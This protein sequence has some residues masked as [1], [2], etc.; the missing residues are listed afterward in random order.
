MDAYTNWALKNDPKGE[1]IQNIGLFNAA[2]GMKWQDM[3]DSTVVYRAGTPENRGNAATWGRFSPG[4]VGGDITV[5]GIKAYYASFDART[6]REMERVGSKEP[7]ATRV[8]QYRETK[9]PQGYRFADNMPA[10]MRGYVKD[11]V[12]ELPVKPST[13]RAFDQRA[14]ALDDALKASLSPEHYNEWAETGRLDPSKM[15]DDEYGKLVKHS[16]PQGFAG[17]VSR[18]PDKIGREEI[19]G[20]LQVVRQWRQPKHHSI[21]AHSYQPNDKQEEV[22]YL[23]PVEN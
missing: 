7:E 3:P 22:G 11:G 21:I 23:Q 14:A 8:P 10:E 4:G 17:M 18:N 5:G 12:L 9:T 6:V 19:P 2:S 13:A 16:G 1:H 20:R 15:S